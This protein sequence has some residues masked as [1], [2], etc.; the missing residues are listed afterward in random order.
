MEEVEEISQLATRNVVVM[1]DMMTSS[2]LKEKR[3]EAEVTVKNYDFMSVLLL[4]LLS[5]CPS[6]SFPFLRGT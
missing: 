6:A 3:L 2:L 5:L 1:H 4:P